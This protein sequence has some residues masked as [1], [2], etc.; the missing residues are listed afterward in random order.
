TRTFH[1]AS[2]FSNSSGF[3]PCFFNSSS[4]SRSAPSYDD[5]MITP[6]L[7]RA[8]TSS[9][10]FASVSCANATLPIIAAET[11][12]TPSRTIDF[13][14]FIKTSPQSIVRNRA[15][16]EQILFW[17]YHPWKR[18]PKLLIFLP[19][20]VEGPDTLSIAQ[21]AGDEH[22]LRGYDPEPRFPM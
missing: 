8:I 20:H 22:I 4:T 3:S 11:N 21:N 17:G 2:C 18:I 7:T 16:K 1:S 12:T 13:I 10:N 5:R 6:A 19:L 14:V 9:T 15:F